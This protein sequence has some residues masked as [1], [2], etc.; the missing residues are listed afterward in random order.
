VRSLRIRIFAVRTHIDIIV[1]FL[2]ERRPAL[3]AHQGIDVLIFGVIF[4]EGLG[5]WGL[6]LI[7]VGAHVATHVF[8]L[9]KVTVHILLHWFPHRH[10]PHHDAPSTRLV[11]AVQHVGFGCILTV[12]AASSLDHRQLLGI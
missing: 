7:M 4:K 1:V 9:V 6:G 2:L 11:G 3:L 5:G 10:R 8:A 12:D